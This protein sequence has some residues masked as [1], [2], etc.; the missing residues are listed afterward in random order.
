MNSGHTCLFCKRVF[1]V[2]FDERDK[3]EVTLPHIA[4]RKHAS[5]GKTKQKSKTKKL[6]REKIALE[7]LH[8]ILGHRSTRSLMY[9]DTDNVCKDIELIIYPDPFCTSYQI[10]SMN[11]K[12]R[13]N[14]HKNPLGR[15]LWI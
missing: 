14:I 7:F 9:G 4:Q 1:K 6:P 8:Q 11:K 15:C 13:Y 10:I 2:Y 5:L 12:A 3:N